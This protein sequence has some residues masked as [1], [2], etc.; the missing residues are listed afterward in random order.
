MTL[1][2]VFPLKRSRIYQRTTLLVLMAALAAT[3]AFPASAQLFGAAPEEPA[4][5]TFAKNGTVDSTF[6]F[7]P[8]DFVVQ[9]GEEDLD[10]IILTSL[11]DPNAGVLTMGNTDL[12][13]GDA[14]AMSAVGGMKF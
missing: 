2:E 12:A 3:M 10:S 1:K 14:V 7:S 13:I 6:S 5:A 9:S 4:V 8:A 11:P